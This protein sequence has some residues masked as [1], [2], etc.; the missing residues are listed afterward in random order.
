MKKYIL[1][2][3]ISPVVLML[4]ACVW[5][6]ESLTITTY[7][8]SPQGVYKQLKLYP[9]NV[10]PACNAANEGWMYYNNITSTFE[11]CTDVSGV[12]A[13]RQSG[14]YALDGSNLTVANQSWSLGMG[15]D[16]VASKIGVDINYTG[17]RGVVVSRMNTDIPAFGMYARD[18]SRWGFTSDTAAGRLTLWNYNNTWVRVEAPL[19]ISRDGKVGLGTFDPQDRLHV[20][21]TVNITN[22][23]ILGCRDGFWPVADGRICMEATMRGPADA[24]TAIGT[25]KGIVPG[26]RVCTHTDFQQ[27]CGAGRTPYTTSTGWYGDHGV[28][29][30]G[31]W[32]D[33]YGTWNT[34]S[35]SNNNDGP[36]N[37]AAAA[38]FNYRCCY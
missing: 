1:F 27:A 24:W 11:V 31:N 28:S 25:C 32:D 26:C 14:L 33:E 9:H 13:Y 4:S 12:F 20:N 38:S 36:A 6:E 37:E 18:D 3:C 19:V 8:P 30:G 35:C 22:R 2:G 10:P 5:A 15:P 7:Y 21:G 34:A 17:S 16:P 23:T 29:S